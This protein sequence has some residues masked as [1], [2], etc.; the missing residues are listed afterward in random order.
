MVFISNA[1][2]KPLVVRDR[3]AHEASLSGGGILD[4]LD[5]QHSC[6]HIVC[7]TPHKAKIY[8]KAIIGD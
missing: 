6:G 7:K 1:R 3:A 8:L 2:I 5:R 4:S